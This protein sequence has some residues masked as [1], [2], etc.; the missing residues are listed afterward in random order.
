MLSILVT[1]MTTLATGGTGPLALCSFA[2]LLVE[3]LRDCGHAVDHRPPEEGED[4]SGYDVVLVGLITPLGAAK[5]LFPALDVIGRARASGCALGFYLDDWKL[6][7]VKT[8]LKF[9]RN[10]LD[11]IDGPRQG[12]LV[13]QPWASEHPDQVACVL[14]AL[15]DRPWP[16]TL[17]PKFSWGDGGRILTAAKIGA[18]GVHFLDPSSYVPTHAVATPSTRAREWVNAALTKPSKAQQQWLRRFRWPVV[19]LGVKR[20]GQPQL[21]EPLLVQ[22]YA[23]ARG[24]ISRP[25]PHKG[26]GWW[27]DRFVFAAQAGAVLYADPAEV[28]DLGGPYAVPLA[29]IEAMSDAELDQLGA[30]QAGHLASRAW[31]RERFRNEL[32][33][34]V[35]SIPRGPV[36]AVA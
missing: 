34:A 1:G 29:Q 24:V 10:H 9:V 2:R 15:L 32:D 33:V 13:S 18:G 17:I 28:A 6:T 23:D 26:S 4:L 35:R 27:R 31:S 21:V 3:A 5:W 12:S 30:D 19:D 7:A 11:W 20:Q 25:Y 8:N 16:S 22:R 14:D 36:S